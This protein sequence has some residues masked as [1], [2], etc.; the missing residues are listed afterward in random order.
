MEKKIVSEMSEYSP[1]LSDG[2]DFITANELRL[3]SRKLPYL[4]R[5]V[6]CFLLQYGRSHNCM[7][8]WKPRD[9]ANS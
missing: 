6:C 5:E 2:G 8:P 4:N 7:L 3:Y 1:T 9:I